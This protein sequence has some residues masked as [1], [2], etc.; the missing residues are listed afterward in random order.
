MYRKDKSPK[1]VDESGS[2]FPGFMNFLVHTK[3]YVKGK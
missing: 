1:K 3:I 2:G